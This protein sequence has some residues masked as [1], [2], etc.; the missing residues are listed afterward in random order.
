MWTMQ[1]IQMMCEGYLF[2]TSFIDSLHY[3][4]NKI[5]VCTELVNSLY[6]LSIVILVFL[7][8]TAL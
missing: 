7:I 1:L 2:K 4:R 5:N 8:P 6:V 3:A